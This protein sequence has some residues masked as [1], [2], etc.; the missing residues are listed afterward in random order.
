M[1]TE[2]CTIYLGFG[3]KVEAGETIEEGARRELLV[4]DTYEL[5]KSLSFTNKELNRKKQR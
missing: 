2:D 4:R 3:G 1:K 5:L